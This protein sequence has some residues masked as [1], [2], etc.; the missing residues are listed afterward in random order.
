MTIGAARKSRA[1]LSLA[2]NCRANEKAL[3][4]LWDY[5]FQGVKGVSPLPFT[6]LFIKWYKGLYQ[7]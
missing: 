6:F 3:S 1:A 4:D 2:R 5:A 7:N